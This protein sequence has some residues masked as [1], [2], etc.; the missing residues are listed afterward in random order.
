MVHQEVGGANG[1][2]FLLT[3]RVHDRA[4]HARADCHGQE[5]TVDAVTVRQAERDV[6]SPTGGVHAQLFAQAAHQSEHLLAG[7]GHGANRHD[8]RVNHDI[9]RR[10]AEIGSAFHD[11]LGHGKADI[12]IGRDAGVVVGNRHDRHV[13]FLDQGQ[14]Q[15]QP[16]FLT[17]DRIQQR[18]A[19]A[20]HQPRFQSTGHRRVD[21]QR[22]VD[23]LL[24]DLDQRLHQG[25]LDKVVVGIAG[26]FGHL[27]GE[28][29]AR[30][31]VQN[32][33]AT[34]DLLQRVL[35]DGLVIARLQFCRQL[36]APG[37]ID[38]LANDGEGFVKADDDGFRF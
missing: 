16:L 36:L 24:H 25:R 1:L 2:H 30:V 20:G 34:G 9:M 19:F 23:G 7:R 29:C 10:N 38:A 21:A 17:G 3:H 15:L 27:V 6:R 31:H 26:V 22:H 32:G 12:G 35:D 4:G 33:R 14:H 11:L 37:G 18:A 8:Q 5:G 28:N 13:V